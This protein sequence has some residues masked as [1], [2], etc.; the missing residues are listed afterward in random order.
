VRYPIAVIAP[1]LSFLEMLDLLNEQLTLRGERPV[2][3]DSDCREGICGMCSLMIDGEAHGPQAETTSCQL[4]M[5]HFRDGAGITIEPF[6]STAFPVL[7]D[8]I[9]DRSALDR[10]MQAGGYISVHSGPKPDPNALPIEPE[11]VEQAL[12]AAACIGCGA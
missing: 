5:R 2:A 9:I 11:V 1:E 3:F 10:I 8:L 6:R 12:D 7:R 4:Y